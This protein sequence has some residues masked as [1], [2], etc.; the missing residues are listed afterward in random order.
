MRLYL[1]AQSKFNLGYTPDW[2]QI[3]IPKPDKPDHTL[4]LTMDIRGEIGYDL[5]SVNLSVKGELVPWTLIDSES[6]KEFDLNDLDDEQQLIY[7]ND[8]FNNN[9]DHASEIVIGFYPVDDD[10]YENHED[11]DIFTE[12]DGQYE[13]I[14]ENNKLKAISFTFTGEVNI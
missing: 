13:F 9:L 12:C 3:T 1:S 4:S 7:Y 14:D 10:S 6:D 5:K 11:N 2:I 8:L